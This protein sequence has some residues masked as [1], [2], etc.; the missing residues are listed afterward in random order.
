MLQLG[1][2]EVC[3][4]GVSGY[5][6]IIESSLDLSI[7][8]GTGIT[9]MTDDASMLKVRFDQLTTDPALVRRFVRASATIAP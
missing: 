7:W 4:A 6:L 3:L 9:I 8:N 5:S 2:N 1:Q